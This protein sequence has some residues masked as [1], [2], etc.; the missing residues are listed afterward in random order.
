MPFEGVWLRH[1]TNA[2]PAQIGDVD[3]WRANVGHAF[4]FAFGTAAAVWFRDAGSS[5]S[6]PYNR[7]DDKDFGLDLSKCCSSP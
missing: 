5:A 6:T 1:C 7:F 3:Y 2:P 4:A